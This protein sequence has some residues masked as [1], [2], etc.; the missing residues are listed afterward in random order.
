S[1][2]LSDIPIKKQ[3]LFLK[4]Q[5]FLILREYWFFFFLF[6][7]LIYGWKWHQYHSDILNKTQQTHAIELQAKNQDIQQLYE[8]LKLEQHTTS[9]ELLR[10]EKMKQDH[11]TK[12]EQL[13]TQHKSLSDEISQCEEY[14][15]FL[16]TQQKQRQEEEK[17]LETDL[18]EILFWSYLLFQE[19]NLEM[20]EHFLKKYAPAHPEFKIFLKVIEAEQ[21]E[22]WQKAMKLLLEIPP[23]F[24]EIA[25]GKMAELS[26]L[27]FHDLKNTRS[28]LQKLE[29]LFPKSIFRVPV[30]AGILFESR[31][32][33]ELYQLLKNVP[34]DIPCA[35]LFYFQGIL[36]CQL[37]NY[38]SPKTW[39]SPA[40]QKKGVRA[41]Q[42]AVQLKPKDPRYSMALGLAFY[43]QNDFLSAGSAFQETIKLRGDATDWSCLAGAFLQL[44]CYSDA[45]IL[46]EKALTMDTEN[47]ITLYFQGLL[48][49]EEKKPEEAL[50]LWE[51]A[52]F[53]WQR[54]LQQ[55]K[56]LF[57]GHLALLESFENSFQSAYSTLLLHL[58]EYK[59]ASWIFDSMLKKN[60]QAQKGALGIGK[61]L[62]FQNQQAQAQDYFRQ[63]WIVAEDK[64]PETFLWNTFYYLKQKELKQVRAILEGT[65]S[66][67]DP[68]PS[69]LLI[70]RE[71][72][73]L[74]PEEFSEELEHLSET[75]RVWTN[76]FIL[77]LRGQVTLEQVWQSTSTSEQQAK[78]YFYLGMIEQQK[79]QET[80]AKEFFEQ[81]FQKQQVLLEEYFMVWIELG[82]YQY[83][84]KK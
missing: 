22:E 81:S 9:L 15:L 74:L 83:F 44:H 72:I 47:E 52:S 77:Y 71:L 80:K 21:Q 11:L 31:D 58:G 16:N 63:A 69:T 43:F 2:Y 6:I 60:T 36:D 46:L 30:K 5:G 24:E 7:T 79:N 67:P 17:K 34:M 42:K 68:I 10:S 37:A 65:F 61:M 3:G 49:I 33:E 39:K 29:A 18:Q 40:N 75:D 55:Q 48:K 38:R 35:S 73:D 82:G 26:L 62:L 57:A 78:T 56:F 28:L 84:N 14:I 59:K 20:A 54:R 70:F 50:S 25:L 76:Q 1:R 64:I 8:F 45:K 19:T 23:P 41:L 66:C 27:H 53:F 4:R 13:L 51:S 32:Y 12:Q